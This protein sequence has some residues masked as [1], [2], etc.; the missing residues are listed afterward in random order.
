MLQDDICVLHSNITI[1]V[2]ID[3]DNE[4]LHIH[5]TTW[6]LK[7]GWPSIL[8]LVCIVAYF[9]N[10]FFL[11]VSFHVPIRKKTTFLILLLECAPLI[12]HHLVN[13]AANTMNF[14]TKEIAKCSWH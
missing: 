3:N 1:V 14:V 7:D 6:S 5:S 8:I 11:N 2:N 4:I 12:D 9:G 10:Y 13:F